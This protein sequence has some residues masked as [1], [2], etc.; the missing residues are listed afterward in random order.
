MNNPTEVLIIDDEPEIRRFL[1]VTLLRHGF[2]KITE[3]VNGTEGLA[4][5]NSHPPHVLILDLGLP[6]MDGTDIIREIREWSTLPII[7]LSAREQ[8]RSKVEA[9]ELGADD[10]LTKPFG[11]EELMAR[12]N[13]ALRHAK[14]RQGSSQEIYEHLG[15]KIDFSKR[16]VLVHGKEVHLTPTEYKILSLFAGHAGQVVTHSTLL[17]EIW[18]KNFPKG[19]NYLR[20]HVQHLREKLGDDPLSPKYITNELGV[21]YRLKAD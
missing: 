4:F 10:Y 3:A 7:V 1:K 21:G 15:L 19:N 11:T 8:E 6:D 20:I 13:V 18:G 14:Q 17:T 2:H 16:L 9:L 5:L 12:V